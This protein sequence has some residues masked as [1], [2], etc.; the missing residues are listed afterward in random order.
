MPDNALAYVYSGAWVAECPA[1]CGNVQAMSR[2]DAGLYH[3]GYCQEISG[4]SWPAE[5]QTVLMMEVLE[6]RP[7][8]SNRNWYPQDHPV[9]VRFG[10]PHGQSV[11]D[12]LDEN[13][14]HGI[15]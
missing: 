3:C 5:Q 7:N 15:F 8:P 10:I 4:I 14:E 11:Q 12:L 6:R 13:A 1:L 2:D 9:A